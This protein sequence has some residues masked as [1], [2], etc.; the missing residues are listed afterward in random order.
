VDERIAADVV[1][2]TGQ[3]VDC[4]S[5]GSDSINHS[6]TARGGSIN[7]IV[8]ATD[9]EGETNA[10]RGFL[11]R[12]TA[13]TGSGQS[14]EITDNDETTKVV[15]VTPDWNTAP[16]TTSQYEIYSDCS[17][18]AGGWPVLSENTRPLTT[19]DRPHE[20]DDNDG[21][22]NLEEWLHDYARQVENG[23]PDTTPP[24]AP[25]NLQVN[26]P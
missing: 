11:I 8:I 17:R 23:T 20:D 10:L 7:T 5:G 2:R 22:T 15:V 12:I 14:R 24:A 19:P 9:S 3:Y 18:N 6:G 4:V 16:D 13:G 21:Y 26:P 25:E 1:A